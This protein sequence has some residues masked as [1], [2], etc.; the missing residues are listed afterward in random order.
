MIRSAVLVLATIGG[1]AQAL[2]AD[3]ER[4]DTVFET[5]SARSFHAFVA[6]RKCEQVLPAETRALN[7]RYDAAMAKLV[8]IYGKVML[9]APP[10]E[11]QAE[12]HLQGMC[13]G[14][15][16]SFDEKVTRIEQRAKQGMQ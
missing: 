11:A 6:A 15:L 14:T 12:T 13:A 5:S 10:R 3:R 16:M 1:A 9:G 7:L 4:N 8:E 2:P